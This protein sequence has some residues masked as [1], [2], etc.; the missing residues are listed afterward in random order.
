ME[1]LVKQSKRWMAALGVVA[2]LMVAGW[3]G[4]AGGAQEVFAETEMA[5][6]NAEAG[7]AGCLPSGVNAIATD[8]GNGIEC[9]KCGGSCCVLKCNI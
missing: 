3:Q 7:S 5:L 4:G 2:F 9:K 6:E 8:T 1:K